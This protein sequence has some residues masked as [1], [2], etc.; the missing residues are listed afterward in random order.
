VI[1]FSGGFGVVVTPNFAGHPVV[2]QSLVRR[3]VNPLDARDFPVRRLLIP[4]FL[5]RLF[6]VPRLP[7]PEGSVPHP[8][9]PERVH[10]AGVE[11]EQPFGVLQRL[12]AGVVWRRHS[13]AASWVATRLRQPVQ[14]AGLR[15]P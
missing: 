14:P 3:G 5:F 6:A 12:V 1:V 11:G 10:L 15:R 9:P 2:I 8:A 4:G 7:F 13:M